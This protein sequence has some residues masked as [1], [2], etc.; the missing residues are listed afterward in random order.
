MVITSPLQAS[1][2]TLIMNG[3]VAKQAAFWVLA[4]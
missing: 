4:R 1:L 3:N 2:T